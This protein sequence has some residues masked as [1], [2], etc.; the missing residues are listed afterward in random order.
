[1]TD[2]PPYQLKR[3][4]RRTLSICV[5]QEGA[6]VVHAPLKM[7]KRDIEAFILQKR[8]WIASKQALV[9]QRPR[10]APE[11]GQQLPWL[12]GWLTVRL[13]GVPMAMD[14][15]GWLLV[16]KAG[17]AWQHLR[18]WRM[19]RAEALLGPRVAYWTA[20]TGLTPQSVRYTNA[21]KRWGSMTS[22]GDM[23]LNAALLHCP[24]EM[25]DY[26]I[27][28]ELC[29]LLHPDHSPAFHAKVRSFLPEADGIRGRMKPLGYLTELLH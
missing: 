16:P 2:L 15:E 19:Q 14:R 12:G 20:V 26:V 4:K 13:C 3:S 28:H 29:H 25:C 21:R 11:D 23:R 17:D 8:D 22:R 18:Q 27:V 10:F 1:M 24:A 5:D 9:L 7:A 6:L